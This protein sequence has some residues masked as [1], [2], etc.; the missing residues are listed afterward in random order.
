MRCTVRLPELATHTDFPSGLT[1]IA[2]GEVCT[3]TVAIT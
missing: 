2:L 3:G 1:A